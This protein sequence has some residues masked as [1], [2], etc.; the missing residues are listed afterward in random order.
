MIVNPRGAGTIVAAQ[1]DYVSA[2]F[3][4]ILPFDFHLRH[5]NHRA[6]PQIQMT[7]DSAHRG[8]WR[9]RFVGS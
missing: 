3:D 9:G 7:D 1:R 2:G 5:R 6:P 4:G 8:T